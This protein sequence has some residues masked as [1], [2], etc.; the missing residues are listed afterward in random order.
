MATPLPGSINP[1]N[2]SQILHQSPLESMGNVSEGS[3]ISF[4]LDPPPSN[5]EYWVD[6]DES[7]DLNDLTTAMP[8]A[9]LSQKQREQQRYMKREKLNWILKFLSQKAEWAP[10]TFIQSFIIKKDELSS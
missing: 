8:L 10:A 9:S 4:L 2:S 7:L 1:S 5:D 6:I 3:D